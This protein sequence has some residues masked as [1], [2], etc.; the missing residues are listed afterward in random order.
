LKEPLWYNEVLL[1]E[2]QVFKF[3]FHLLWQ[4]LLL[5]LLFLFHE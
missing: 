3:V 4:L 1:P 5:L 2:L